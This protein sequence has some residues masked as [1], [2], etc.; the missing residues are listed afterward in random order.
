MAAGGAEGASRRV[1]FLARKAFVASATFDEV[2][3]PGC[4]TLG[5]PLSNSAV[6]ALSH[7]LALSTVGVGTTP[8]DRSDLSEGRAPPAG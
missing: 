7:S 3:P 4:V 2:L 8:S 1:D 6:P 5:A